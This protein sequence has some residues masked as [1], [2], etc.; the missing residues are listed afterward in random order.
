MCSSK[1]VDLFGYPNIFKQFGYPN[2]KCLYGTTCIESLKMMFYCN[3]FVV[4]T[5][6]TTNRKQMIKILPKLDA[7]KIQKRFDV[8]IRVY[9]SM[10]RV[11]LTVHIPYVHLPMFWMAAIGPYSSSLYIPYYFWLLSPLINH[12]ITDYQHPLLQGVGGFVY[13]L[14]STI[15]Y[16]NEQLAGNNQ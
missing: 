16:G 6:E 4:N 15:S 12:I 8:Q 11:S 14:L 3:V 1:T 7:V 13:P 2:R 9:G 5:S 10:H